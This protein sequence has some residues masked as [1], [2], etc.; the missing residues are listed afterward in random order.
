MTDVQIEAADGGTFSAYLA[1]PKGTGKAPGMIVIQEIFGINGNVRAIC[2]DYASKGYVALAPDLFWRQQPGVQLDSNTKEGWN[3]AMKLFQG[4][5]ET[6]GIED[7]TAALAWLREH[8]RVSGK[9]GCVGYCLGGKLAYLMS[10][11]SDVDASVGYYGVAIEGSL[12]EA[13]AITEPLMLHLAEK[14]SFSTPAAQKQVRESL[15]PIAHVTVHVYPGQDHAFAR[16]G[17]EHYDAGAAK[18]ADG[19]TEQFFADY[20]KS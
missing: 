5:S 18:L 2:D 19:R 4:F 12:G 16:K 14:D 20:L 7:L 10:T 13:A 3:E 8:P 6:K 11:R 15:A 9:A 17:G 1:E